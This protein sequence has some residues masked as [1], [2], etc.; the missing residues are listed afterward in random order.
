RLCVPALLRHSRPPFELVFLDAGSLDGTA[1]F[2]DG[3][4]LAAPVRVEV[5]RAETDLDI[6]GACRQALARGPGGGLGLVQK[7]TGRGAGV[8]DAARGPGGPG[9]VHCP[10]GA[11]VQPG[12]TA[13]ESGGGAVPAPRGERRGAGRGAGGAVRPRV[14]RA[15]PGALAGGR[16]AG[17][18]LPA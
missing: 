2:L 18:V 16:A 6:A 9:P 1:E 8:A 4:A 12:G 15:A 7:R 10:G 5:V 3:V 13:A 14:P 17:R 11:D